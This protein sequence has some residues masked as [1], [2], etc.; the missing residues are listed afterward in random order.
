MSGKY[1]SG[2]FSCCSDMQICCLGT[3]YPCC[4][5]AS[6]V[7]RLRE[8][9]CTFC[10][11]IFQVHPFWVRQMVKDSKGIQKHYLNDCLAVVFCMPCA[12]CQDSREIFND[13]F[14]STPMMN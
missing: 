13:D 9:D 6:N 2:L 1:H 11:C 8:E 10:H 3:F 5:N 4:L 12:V 14:D 7:A